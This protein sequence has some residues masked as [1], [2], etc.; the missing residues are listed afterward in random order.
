MRVTDKRKFGFFQ[1]DNLIITQYGRELGADGIA[2]YCVLACIAGGKGSAYPRQAMLGEMIGLSRM[3]VNRM[4]RDLQRLGLIY[5]Q[6]RR[7]HSSR[8]FLCD[9]KK[10]SSKE[11]N[12]T[13]LFE[14]SEAIEVA[15]ASYTPCDPQLQPGV[16]VGYNGCAGQAHITIPNEQDSFEQYSTTT[17]S[18]PRPDA[19]VVDVDVA[20]ET[21]LNALASE[22]E[23]EGVATDFC[24]RYLTRNCD[25]TLVRVALAFYRKENSKGRGWGPG[26]LVTMLEQPIVKWSFR[27][28]EHGWDPPKSRE[29]KGSKHDRQRTSMRYD[30]KRD[31]DGA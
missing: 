3:Q 27:R 8:Y 7:G 16:T 11:S 26:A 31:G 1:V 12:A 22:L 2:V 23:A 18:A 15:P 4:M 24:G 6:K 9:P 21:E 20:V 17:G 13:P 14:G 25:R 5:A 19:V 10:L 30:P 28:T 29:S